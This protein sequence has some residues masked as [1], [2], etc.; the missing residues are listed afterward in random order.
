MGLSSR[1]KHLLAFLIIVMAFGLRLIQLGQQ[2]LWFDEGWSWHLAQLPLSQMFEETAGDRSPVLYYALLHGWIGVAGMTEFALRLPSVLADVVTVSVLIKFGRALARPGRSVLAMLGA[3]LWTFNPMA[4]WYAQETRM[5]ALLCTLCTASMF[6]LWLWI[7]RP[8]RGARPLILSSVLIGLALQTHYYAVFLLVVQGLLV[9]IHTGNGYLR[10]TFNWRMVLRDY[11]IAGISIVGSTLPW[12]VYARQGFS[13]NDGFFSPVNTIDGR[14]LE[15]FEAFQTGGLVIPLAWWSL[16]GLL[17]TFVAMIVRHAL[18]RKLAYLA[19]LL[20]AGFGAVVVAAIFI[21]LFFPSSSVFHPRYLIFATPLLLLA[22]VGAPSGRVALAA[23]TQPATRVT[24]LMVS[25]AITAIILAG[26]WLPAILSEY[27]TAAVQR[28]DTRAAVRHVVD[29]LASGDAVLM[30]RDNFAIRYYWQLESLRLPGLPQLRAAP[31]DL[32]GVLRS[33]ET[34]LHDLNAAPIQRVRLML[35]QDD[36]VDPQRLVEST[37]WNNGYELGQTSF[38]SI[39]LP[40]YR[41]R[42]WPVVTPEIQSERALFDGQLALTGVWIPDV[43]L[44]GHGL[45][46]ILRWQPQARLPRS[47]KVY[48]HVF[49]AAGRPVFQRDKVSLNALVPMTQWK[50]GESLQDPFSLLIPDQLPVGDYTL[51]VGVYDPQDNGRRLNVVGVHALPAGDEVEI[52]TVRIS[53]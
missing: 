52:G 18:T 26:L 6:C 31:Y 40:L 30:S 9:L 5:Y 47:Y 42:R 14:I 1:R 23:G 11:C 43:A 41:V 48:V 16:G 13:Y 3:L 39:T 28:D 46:V 49:D 44:R 37:L 33:N 50:P 12:L 15:W 32:H 17:F 20:C 10:R 53:D 51:R 45:G 29:G 27:T 35:W 7:R 24:Q 8:N 38:G 4:V 19:T 34:V 2:S 22:L 36:V 21:R 25:P